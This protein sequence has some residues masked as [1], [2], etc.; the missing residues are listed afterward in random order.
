MTAS[1]L[2]LTAAAAAL[3]ALPTAGHAATPPPRVA[4]EMSGEHEKLVGLL[5]QYVLIPLVIAAVVAV[6][7]GGGDEK[8]ASP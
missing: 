5:W 8:P 6:L 4:A 1:K 2:V 7:A 3:A